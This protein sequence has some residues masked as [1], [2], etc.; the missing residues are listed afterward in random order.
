MSLL[1]VTKWRRLTA[2]SAVPPARAPAAQLVLACFD[3]S[4]KRK[5]VSL[6]GYRSLVCECYTLLFLNSCLVF[7]AQT[8]SRCDGRNLQ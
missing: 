8:S 6:C 2:N 7:R 3:F 1:G 4:A 5:R